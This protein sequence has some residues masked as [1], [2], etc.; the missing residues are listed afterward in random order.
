[1][2][3]MEYIIN[4]A[5]AFHAF[6][7]NRTFARERGLFVSNVKLEREYRPEAKVL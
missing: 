2:P 1:M 3:G 5:L 7:S 4:A 6:I